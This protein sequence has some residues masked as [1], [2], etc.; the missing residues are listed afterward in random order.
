MNIVEN[1]RLIQ[2]VPRLLPG[3]CGIS[4][5]AVTLASELKTSYGIS[6]AFV[7]L[8]SDERSD[9]PYPTLRCAPDQLLNAC[10]A[11][12]GSSSAAMLVHLSGYGYAANGAPTLLADALEQVRADSR[13]P[14]AVF[15]HELFA[16]GMPW[17]SAF[18]YAW[19]QKKAYRRIAEVCDLAVTNAHVFADWLEREMALS[20]VRQ[21]ISL[22]ASAVQCLPV[23]SLAGEPEHL[24]G[25]A[26]R[27]RVMA[28]FGLAGTRQRAY[29][30]LPGLGDLLDQLGIQKILD[31]GPE[32]EAPCQVNGIPL[33]RMGV[34]AATEIDRLLSQIAFGY[35]AYPPNCLAKSGVFAAY[36]AHGVIPVIARDFQKEFDGLRDGVHLLSPQTA[37]TKSPA[38]LEKCS[39]AVWRWYRGHRLH[40]HAA[41]YDRWLGAADEAGQRG[42]NE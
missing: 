12:S 5:H 19:R 28:V 9:L 27:D 13:F 1:R 29:R 24:A 17:T 15:F 41:I 37:R 31:I 10:V 20:S 42:E 2:V 34:L 21:S 4:D 14:I 32:C 40:D 6:A 35:L 33:K 36:S 25:I 22:S 16:G 30:E 38:G 3:R 26:Q 11:L 7:V 18:W 23:F 8:N 39:R